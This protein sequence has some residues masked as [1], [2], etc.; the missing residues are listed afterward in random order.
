MPDIETVILKKLFKNIR[1]IIDFQPQ[2][3]II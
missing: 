2:Y 3:C 1:K